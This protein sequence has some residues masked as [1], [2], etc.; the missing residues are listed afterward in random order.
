MHMDFKIL[1][2]KPKV[3]DFGQMFVIAK[4]KTRTNGK[5]TIG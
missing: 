4:K 5:K 2:R 3:Q 1:N